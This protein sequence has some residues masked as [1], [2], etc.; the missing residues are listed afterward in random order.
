MLFREREVDNLHK[1]IYD[2]VTEQVVDEKAIDSNRYDVHHL[3]LD[4]FKNAGLKRM[5]KSRFVTG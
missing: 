3:K 2:D 5:L 4:I 1:L